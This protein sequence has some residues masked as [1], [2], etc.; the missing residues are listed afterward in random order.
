MSQKIAILEAGDEK[1]QHSYK[2][3]NEYEIEYEIYVPS[4]ITALNSFINETSSR[5]NPVSLE[6]V[7]EFLS[8]CEIVESSSKIGRSF[9]FI[10]TKKAVTKE[11]SLSVQQISHFQERALFYFSAKKVFKS[12]VNGT[13]HRDESSLNSSS[14]QWLVMVKLISSTNITEGTESNPWEHN[15]EEKVQICEQGKTEA[16]KLFKDGKMRPA[17]RLYKRLMWEIENDVS[18]SPEL[19]KQYIILSLNTSTCFFKE[20]DF[21][22]SLK[23]C[24][25]CLEKLTTKGVFGNEGKTGEEIFPDLVV[26]SMKAH[27]RK[28]QCLEEESEFEKAK[29]EYKTALGFAQDKQDTQFMNSIKDA[30]TKLQKKIDQ[31][32]QKMKKA[33]SGMFSQ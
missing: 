14:S 2:P 8:S 30:L 29:E 23:Y 16:N 20:K 6:R 21:K 27:H 25:K 28:G 5:S 3:S 10:P 22:T 32:N 31:Y 7:K 33:F 1:L 17:R 26:Q 11:F 15:V 13:T 18:K 12:N 4:S 19:Y 24:E 9:K